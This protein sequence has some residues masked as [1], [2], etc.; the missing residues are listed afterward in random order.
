MVANRKKFSEMNNAELAHYLVNS[1]NCDRCVFSKNKYACMEN[2]CVRGVAEYLG[3]EVEE[4]GWQ[5][6]D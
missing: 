4:D 5:A 1:C 2:S 3:Q 6:N